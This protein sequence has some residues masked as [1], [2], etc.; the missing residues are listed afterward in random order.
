MFLPQGVGDVWCRK[1]I[2]QYIEIANHVVQFLA[3]FLRHIQKK[4][5][6]YTNNNGGI[7][8]QKW[9]MMMHVKIKTC[10]QVLGT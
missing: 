4:S 7:N 3:C 1:T 5:G 2:G 8:Q 9:N 6:D 10:P